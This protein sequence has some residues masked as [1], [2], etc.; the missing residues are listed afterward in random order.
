MKGKNDPLGHL[1]GGISRELR[2]IKEFDQNARRTLAALRARIDT[3][4]ADNSELRGELTEQHR[5]EGKE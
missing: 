4:E 5:F 1:C 2:H 3:L